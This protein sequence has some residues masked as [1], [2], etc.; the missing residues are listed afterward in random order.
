MKPNYLVILP[1]DAASTVSLETYPSTQELKTLRK[2][3]KKWSGQL[4]SRDRTRTL[5][6][7][8]KLVL[9]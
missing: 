1:I 3:V 7:R 4:K 6:I 9:T 5:M 2:A 8:M